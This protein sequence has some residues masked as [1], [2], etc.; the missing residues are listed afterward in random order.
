[1]FSVFDTDII[2]DIDDENHH[3]NNYTES[4]PYHYSSVTLP[5]NPDDIYNLGVS[6]PFSPSD[7]SANTSGN[8]SPLS[9]SPSGEMPSTVVSQ[10][11]EQMGQPD[12]NNMMP[13][14]TYEY[15]GV[16]YT[17]DPV[18]NVMSPVMNNPQYYNS[19]VN[20]PYLPTYPANSGDAMNIVSYPSSSST[21]S[22]S[23]S[24][25]DY[26][27]TQEYKRPKKRKRKSNVELPQPNMISGVSSYEDALLS[28]DSVSF[29]EYIDKAN[30]YQRFTDQE[31][32][33]IRDI[34][35][36]IKNRE[37]ARKC[38]RS[39]LTKLEILQG[40]VNEMNE[41]TIILRE[42]NSALKVENTKLK[43]EVF[44]LQDIINGNQTYL[45]TYNEVKRPIKEEYQLPSQP[46]S[47]INT[48]S[49]FLFVLLFSF[50]IFWNFDSNMLGSLLKGTNKNHF[51]TE[52]IEI[53]D[54]MLDQI[55]DKIKDRNSPNKYDDHL[56]SRYTEEHSKY[57]QKNYKKDVEICCY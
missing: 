43:N 34:R 45:N 12:F 5:S 2:S 36:R 14:Y 38:R 17:Y 24:L 22:L 39:R 18:N 57:S 25:A 27:D 35:R 9:T 31:K 41:E 4:Y 8:I 20:V 40:K 54:H 46:N 52:S 55:F 42:E 3:N 33:L 30:S 32:E 21:S 26:E 11:P 51:L 49:I 23:S 13:G 1:M 47:V 44:F 19:D 7:N 15:G 53:E 56:S 10:Y 6:L 48:Q 28:L 29:D 37:S 16:I 50:G